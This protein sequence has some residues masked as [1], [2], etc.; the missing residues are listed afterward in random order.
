MTHCEP[1]T[2]SAEDKAAAERA[3]ALANVW[4]LDPA[5]KGTYPAAFPGGNPLDAMGVK[6]GD[7]DMVK[8]PLDF[9]GINYYRRTIIAAAPVSS[10]PSQHR[11]LSGRQ[12][13]GRRHRWS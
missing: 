6:P 10:D 9:L 1:A 8:A 13:T 11:L 5:L 3:H 2:S 7:M 12:R 4:F